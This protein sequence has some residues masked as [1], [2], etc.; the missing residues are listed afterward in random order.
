MILVVG[1]LLLCKMLTIYN[2]ME[3]NEIAREACINNIR[4]AREALVIA[5]RQADGIWFIGA[6]LMA[7]LA[8]ILSFVVYFVVYI[9]YNNIRRENSSRAGVRFC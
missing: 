2:A 9:P 6:V 7:N 3:A 4:V 8:V 1:S 5:G